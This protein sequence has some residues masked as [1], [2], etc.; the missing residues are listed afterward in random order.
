MF[1]VYFI[2]VMRIGFCPLR[3][4]D[5]ATAFPAQNGTYTARCILLREAVKIEIAHIETS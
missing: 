3:V 5:A 4:F 1:Y 2:L